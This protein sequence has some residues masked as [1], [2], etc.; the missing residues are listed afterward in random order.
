MHFCLQE[1]PC[2]G[3][4]TIQEK[5]AFGFV[6]AVSGLF[7]NLAYL[8]FETICNVFIKIAA[9]VEQMKS[10]IRVSFPTAPPNTPVINVML[11]KLAAPAP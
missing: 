5:N 4:S 9:R 8:T 7:V 2:S 11:V 6:R 1:K 3:L 10:R